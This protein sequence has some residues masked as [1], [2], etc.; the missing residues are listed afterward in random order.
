MI[1][2]FLACCKKRQLGSHQSRS[3]LLWCRYQI[4]VTFYNWF[5]TLLFLTYLSCLLC[6]RSNIRCFIPHRTSIYRKRNKLKTI[7]SFEKFFLN[8]PYLVA[9]NTR[10]HLFQERTFSLP[11]MLNI[12]PASSECRLT[13]FVKFKSRF[14]KSLKANCRTTRCDLYNFCHLTL[15]Q[16]RLQY[17]RNS[18]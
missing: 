10:L 6:L 12:C 18:P 11:S 2:A 9:G 4:M 17:S 13:C 8:P 5:K 14:G 1:H 16:K 3:A 15:L 7:N